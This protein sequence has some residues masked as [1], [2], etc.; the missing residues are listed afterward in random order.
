M[1]TNAIQKKRN[2][3]RYYWQPV[4]RLKI[5]NFVLLRAEQFLNHTFYHFSNRVLIAFSNKS[6]YITLSQQI[7]CDSH[8]APT[9]RSPYK[10]LHFSEQPRIGWKLGVDTWTSLHSLNNCLPLSFYSTYNP[11]SFY[12]GLS[13]LF[14]LLSSSFWGFFHF[15]VE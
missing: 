3:L 2:K 14:F 9:T 12:S 15:A 5:N 13:F 11:V 4:I 8:P 1:W 6:I 7:I 10:S